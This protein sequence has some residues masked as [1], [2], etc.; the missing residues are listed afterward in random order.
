MNCAWHIN[1]EAVRGCKLCGVLICGDCANALDNKCIE[2]E[3]KELGQIKYDANSVIYSGIPG[4]L[5]GVLIVVLSYLSSGVFDFW[6]QLLSSAILIVLCW[7]VSYGWQ[8]L[9]E[10]TSGLFLF[11]PIVGW[12][13]YFIVKGALAVAIG[14]AVGALRCEKAVRALK[15]VR[16][17]EE[18]VASLI[19]K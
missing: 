7:G 3:R 18:T 2:C 17:R 19:R 13:F 10:I 15:Y 16:K 14:W 11:L 4:L 1:K 9:S 12:V 6:R 8:K 5:F